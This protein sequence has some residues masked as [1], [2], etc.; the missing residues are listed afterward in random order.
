MAPSF[1][2]GGWFASS[3]GV[4]GKIGNILLEGRGD[5]ATVRELLVADDAFAEADPDVASLLTSV[6][7]GAKDNLPSATR[8]RV[9]PEGL[10][11]WREA[12]RIV[13]AR[14]TWRSYGSFIER[15]KPK[16]GPG[17]RERM[18]IASRITSA[19]ADTAQKKCDQVRAHVL[20]L[21]RP[22][23]IV[24]LPA[25]PTIA[26]RLNLPAAEL[27]LFRQRTF[28]LTCISGLSGLPQVAIPAGT[29]SGC[30][31]GISFIGWPRS[32]ETLLDLAVRL[33]PFMGA[34]I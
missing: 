1:D 8:T 22:G 34:T 21:V 25:A 26:P 11:S 24:A 23:T 19:E 6:L 3:P 12:F 31:I 2:T 18:E 27:D 16:L 10:D 4:F 33:A 9:S 5:D 14:E 17:V 29:V 32:D 30:P 28:R 15:H 13:Q 7:S 20:D